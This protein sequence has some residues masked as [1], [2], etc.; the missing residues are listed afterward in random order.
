MLHSDTSLRAHPLESLSLTRRG[1][2]ESVWRVKTGV[3]FRRNCCALG[4]CEMSGD[5]GAACGGSAT[6]QVAALVLAGATPDAAVLVGSHRELEALLAHATVSAHL[7]SAH[8]HAHGIAGVADW[9]E[10]L[11]VGV[12]AICVHP[13]GVVSGT[14]GEALSKDRHSG[15][16]PK[17]AQGTSQGVSQLLSL[18]VASAP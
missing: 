14:E 15:H 2:S 17:C 18:G 8:Q 4:T 5:A 1:Y 12:A 9:K 6:T 7:A 11:G 3:K 16:H 13:P 10:Q